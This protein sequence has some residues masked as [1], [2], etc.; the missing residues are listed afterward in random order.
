MNK[1]SGREV[2]GGLAWGL[3]N[4][5]AEV[6][7]GWRE[8]LL[9][10]HKYGGPGNAYEGKGKLTPRLKD[11]ICSYFFLL[12]VDPNTHAQD[13]PEGYQNKNLDD[14][15]VTTPPDNFMMPAWAGGDDDGGDQEDDEGGDQGGDVVLPQTE[16]PSN[17]RDRHTEKRKRTDSDSEETESEEEPQPQ[18][19]VEVEERPRILL[20]IRK[21]ALVDQGPGAAAS[22]PPKKVARKP[23]SSLKCF[24]C[25]EGMSDM[26]KKSKNYL[27]DCGAL[28]R[29]IFSQILISK[30][31]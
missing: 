17:S 23:A 29:V 19:P 15:N 4:K 6:P 7:E 25:K 10:F 8:D 28:G 5:E 20:T 9:E 12:G 18:E 13:V 16:R 3:F 30:N 27:V 2:P 14:L 1:L 21:S 31:R 11:I 26:D 24:Q 22:K